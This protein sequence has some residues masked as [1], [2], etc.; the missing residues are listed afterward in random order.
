MKLKTDYAEKFSKKNTIEIQGQHWG[1]NE[2]L[3]M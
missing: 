3:S 2:Q 1:G